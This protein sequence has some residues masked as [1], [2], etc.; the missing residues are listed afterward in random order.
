MSVWLRERATKEGHV[1]RVW[2]VD[3]KF[4]RANSRS[5]R[6]RR[7]SPVQSKR[8]A[9]AFERQLREQL[10]KNDGKLD[11]ELKPKEIPTVQRF[12]PQYE[13]WSSVNNKPSNQNA[14]RII[15]KNHV[16]PFF[17]RM[18]LD[19]IGPQQI[20]QF[21]AK[22]VAEGKKPSTVNN[23]L[24]VLRKMLDVAVDYGLLQH[25]PR[26]KWMKVPKPEFEFLDFDEAARLI[27]AAEP[28][29]KA[30]IV[31]GLRT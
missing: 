23:F 2:M 22:V 30:M 18:H 8:G 12:W 16:L 4:K 5:V 15:M 26:V 31:M 14:K 20:E 21:R 24:T 10:L 27:A 11:E 3:V 29:W 17:G 6:M 7:R 13:A 9:E 28:E 19:E 25:V 1:D